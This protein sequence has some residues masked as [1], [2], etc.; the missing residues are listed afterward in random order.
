[1]ARGT[2]TIPTTRTVRMIEPNDGD[3]TRDPLFPRTL[4]GILRRS[5]GVLSFKEREDSGKREPKQKLDFENR[6]TLRVEPSNSSGQLFDH[7]NEST[8]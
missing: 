6:A 7:V 4:R 8:N 1:M 2:R 5:T 3:H